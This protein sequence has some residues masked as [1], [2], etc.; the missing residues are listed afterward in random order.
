MSVMKKFNEQSDELRKQHRAEVNKSEEQMDA[1][2]AEFKRDLKEKPAAAVEEY[3]AP[4]KETVDAI[5]ALH[6]QRPLVPIK[7]RRK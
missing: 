4:L 6:K 2:K 3:L 7:V 5:E 1:L